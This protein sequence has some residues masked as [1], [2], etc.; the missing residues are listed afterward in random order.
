MSMNFTFKD[1]AL[2]IICGFSPV[3]DKKYQIYIAKSGAFISLKK[4]PKTCLQFY[5]P[6]RLTYLK[7][8]E[9]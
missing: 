4:N 8:Y 3:Y 5:I 7:T 6:L 2:I 9:T 1:D